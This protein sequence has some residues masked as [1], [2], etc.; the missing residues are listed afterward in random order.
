[1]AKL[2]LDSD[3]LPRLEKILGYTFKD[4]NL[5]RQAISHRSYCANHN[6]RLEFLGDA[7]LG[8][9]IA[10]ELYQRFPHASEG[11]MTRL[12]SNLVKGKTLAKLAL[13]LSLGDY[14]LL[15]AGEL[16]SGGFRRESILADAFEAIVAG[17][18]LEVGIEAC[19][20]RL[21]CWYETL[22]NEADPTQITKDPKTRLQEQM[23]SLKLP[24]PHYETLD[25]RGKDHEQQ[26]EVQCTCLGN[27]KIQGCSTTAI[28][29]SRRQAESLAAEKA[30]QVLNN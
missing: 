30:L 10:D 14:L 6:E 12:R 8:F 7:I 19:R 20:D 25:I 18:Y 23:Q 4:P 2:R 28:A 3:N 27:D 24:L 21:M 13:K 5:L 11:Q 29:S 22:L 26:F 9:I 16:K 1:M 17:I 15:G